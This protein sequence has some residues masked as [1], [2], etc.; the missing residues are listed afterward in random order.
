VQPDAK[1]LIPAL[2]VFIVFSL[3]VVALDIVIY[4]QSELHDPPTGLLGSPTW[5]LT[6]AII[7]SGLIVSAFGATVLA[8]RRRGGFGVALVVVIAVITTIAT[9]LLTSSLEGIA[10]PRGLQRVPGPAAT[11]Q[12]ALVAKTAKPGGVC[13][14]VRSDP[15]HILVTPYQRCAYLGADGRSQ[16][17]YTR[18]WNAPA[19]DTANNGFI[20]TSRAGEPIAPD[21]CVSHLWG[22]WWAWMSEGSPVRPCPYSFDF[23]PAP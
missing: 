11:A 23:I 18:N 2:L 6:V 4:K 20:Y 5:T 16:V 13:V 17:V 8:R 19:G 14:I 10:V 3:L 22:H 12:A 21:T 1:R 15:L 9:F 7:S